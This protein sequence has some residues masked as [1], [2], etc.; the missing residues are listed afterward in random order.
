MTES[1]L[2]LLYDQNNS[3][4][5]LT[6]VCKGPVSTQSGHSLIGV[7]LNEAS[8]ETPEYVSFGLIIVI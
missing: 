3:T 6:R 7:Y 1:P 2:L 8:D 4:V 5:A